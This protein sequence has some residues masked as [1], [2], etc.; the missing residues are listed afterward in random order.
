MTPLSTT[1]IVPRP[2]EVFKVQLVS[3]KG[4]WGESSPPLFLRDCVHEGRG[5]PPSKVVC[6]TYIYILSVR[7]FSSFA[8][9]MKARVTPCHTFPDW[10]E[11][12][13]TYGN[14]CYFK[15]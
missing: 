3:T 6:C 10:Q 9:I 14:K 2:F 13:G 4:Q 7:A 15:H 1:V 5:S 8:P 11:C 12:T